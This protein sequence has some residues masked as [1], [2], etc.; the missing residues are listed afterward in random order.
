MIL[1]V[2]GCGCGC[3]R[4]GEL[5]VRDG[6]GL[7]HCGVLVWREWSS[8]GIRGEKLVNSTWRGINILFI[9]KVINNILNIINYIF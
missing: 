3:G 9:K 7:G 1:G 4:G 2:F 5:R 8:L 6:L